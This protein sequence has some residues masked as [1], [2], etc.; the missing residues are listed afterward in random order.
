MDDDLDDII[1][2]LN[3]DKEEFAQKK[4]LLLSS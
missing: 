1:S 3:K 2:I 4:Q